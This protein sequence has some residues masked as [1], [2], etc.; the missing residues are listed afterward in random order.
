MRGANK[1]LA[2]DLSGTV[3]EILGTCFSVGCQVD[4]RSPKDISDEI[5]EGTIDGLLQ[6]VNQRISRRL[7]HY[8]FLLNR[9]D[10][11]HKFNYSQKQYLA[12]NDVQLHIF[13]CSSFMHRSMNTNE[14]D[15]RLFLDCSLLLPTPYKCLTYS[16]Y[17]LW[18]TT[19]LPTL[20]PSSLLVLLHRKYLRRRPILVQR[21]LTTWHATHHGVPVHGTKVEAVIHHNVSTKAKPNIS[22]FH[23]IEKIVGLM[24]RHH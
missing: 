12:R 23:G 19:P 8:Q 21:R 5:K 16:S 3:R 2:K 24:A 4:G 6:V 7:T 14:N 10:K 20:W 1:S 17:L 15:T 13:N 9:L 18:F 11:R 22:S